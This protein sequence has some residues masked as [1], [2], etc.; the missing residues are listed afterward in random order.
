M[1]NAT[2]AEGH[3]GEYDPPGLLMT[4]SALEPVLVASKLTMAWRI[5]PS[6]GHV[7]S[8]SVCVVNDPTCTPW[9]EVSWPCG[10]TRPI[11]TRPSLLTVHVAENAPAQLA[12]WGRLSQSLELRM[13]IWARTATPRQTAR[14]TPRQSAA[15][16]RLVNRLRRPGGRNQHDHLVYELT[17]IDAFQLWEMAPS[18]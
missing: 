5:E 9:L 11:V 1:A 18:V 4:V 10:T 17:Q 12:G 3:V 7:L 14:T 6:E 8:T 16:A 2:E 15:F 13:T